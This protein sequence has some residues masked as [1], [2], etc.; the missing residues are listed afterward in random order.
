MI[1]EFDFPRKRPFLY[2]YSS[3]MPGRETGSIVDAMCWGSVTGGGGELVTWTL[4]VLIP[5]SW[6]TGRVI[7]HI[8][9]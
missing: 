1:L 8:I 7:F 9:L 6:F 2:I 4:Q 5:F 3:Y